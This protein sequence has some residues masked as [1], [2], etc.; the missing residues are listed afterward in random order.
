VGT[1]CKNESSSFKSVVWA[2][3]TGSSSLQ[4]G[5]SA[6]QRV[7]WIRDYIQGCSIVEFWKISKLK[8]LREERVPGMYFMHAKHRSGANLPQ[9]KDLGFV[10]P[11]GKVQ[12]AF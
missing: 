11:F 10:L 3:E 6:G 5:V 1:A 8:E 2:G 12:K 9:L 4:R 7:G